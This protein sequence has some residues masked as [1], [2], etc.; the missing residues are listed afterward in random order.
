MFVYSWVFLSSAL[1]LLQPSDA[2]YAKTCRHDRQCISRVGPGSCCAPRRPIFSPLPVCKTAGQVGDMCQRSGEGLSY[3][4]SVW[5]RQYIFTCPCAVG[6][7][8]QLSPGY[9][10]IGTCVYM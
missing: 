7:R 3:P 8:C 9:N 10:D 1:L 4:T 6:L 2:I 5:H